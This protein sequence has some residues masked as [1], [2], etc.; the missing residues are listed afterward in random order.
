MY[1]NFYP[2]K[3]VLYCNAVLPKIR[4][5]NRHLC[6]DVIID[7]PGSTKYKLYQLYIVW[8]QCTQELSRCSKMR[9]SYWHTAGC[10]KNIIKEPLQ[11]ISSY[12]I[13]MINTQICLILVQKR[14][15]F[16]FYFLKNQWIKLRITFRTSIFK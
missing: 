4:T 1:C 10:I 11:Y 5:K 15:A 6:T 13:A 14:V 3:N 8:I 2:K 9:A 16:T 7:T 12:L